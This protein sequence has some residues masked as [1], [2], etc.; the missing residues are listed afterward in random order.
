MRNGREL[1]KISVDNNP[2]EA[3]H[4]RNLYAFGQDI[5]IDDYELYY[6]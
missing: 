5:L 6:M 2:E 1:F 3:F 4:G